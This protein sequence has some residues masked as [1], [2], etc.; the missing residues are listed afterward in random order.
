MEDTQIIN[1]LVGNMNEEMM[2]IMFSNI[3]CFLHPSMS[4][5]VPTSGQCPYAVSPD[6]SHPAYSFIYCIQPHLDMVIEDRNIN[7]PVKGNQ[8]L[9][10]MSPNIRHQEKRVEFFQSYIAILIDKD[11]FEEI[12]AQY[13]SKLRLFKGEMYTASPE[14]LSLLKCFMLEK[15]QYENYS[16]LDSMVRIITHSLARS[17]AGSNGKNIPI[18][19]KL[20]VDRAVAYMREHISETVTLKSLADYV[21]VSEGHFSRIFKQYTD[22]TPMDFLNNMRLD[23]ARNM[24]TNGVSNMTDIA[25]E[26]GFK[27]P[28]YFST[29][30]LEKYHVSPSSYMKGLR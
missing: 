2:K 16:L 17:V 20:E 19:D 29:R 24:L 6:H 21:N 3:E 11:Y 25:M 12:Y 15:R 28:S 1:S 23:K 4:I 9:S 27:S 18:Y 8:C 30:F 22:D 10:V 26:C 5:F 7:I 14:L 13:S